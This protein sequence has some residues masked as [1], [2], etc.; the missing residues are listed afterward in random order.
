MAERLPAF[1]TFSIGFE[2]VAEEAGNEFRYSDVV[3]QR[4][5]TEHQ[6][7]FVDRTR[8]LPE[9]ADCVATM[10]E[11]QVSHDAIGF[12]LLA[13]E[14]SR[15]SKV[16]LT[17]Q[18]ADEIFAGYHWY[19][20]IRDDTGDPVDRYRRHFCDRDH[21]EVLE[22][23]EPPFHTAADVS[24]DFVCRAFARWE[25]EEP[26]DLALHLDT[27]VMLVEDPVKRVDNMTMAWGLEARVPFLD[28]EVVELAA[29]IPARHK[30]GNGGK[31][32]LKRAA[33]RVIPPEVIHR[34]KGYFPVPA[35][36]Y[37]E[38]EYLTF[39]R[40]VLDSAAARTRGVFRRPYVDRL[41]A[42]PRDH[43]TVLDGSKLWQVTL[44]E[45]WLQQLGA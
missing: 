16:V 40:D 18:G 43:I 3:A 4:F 17:G 11:P 24:R 30:L 10:A 12:F 42:A 23:L 29:R 35:L 38:G 41:L 1:R 26:V 9:L 7:I 19:P 21:A 36:K 44:L 15:D 45:Y 34:P 14:V 6:R 25:G 5:G 39:A 8:L 27:T 37:L 22:A 28:H 32:V 33:E 20:R 2:D 13:R 31:H